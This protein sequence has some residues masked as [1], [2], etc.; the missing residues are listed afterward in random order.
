MKLITCPDCGASLELSLDFTLHRR[1]PA[2]QDTPL[3]EMEL[4]VRSY[5]CL[6]NEA[7]YWGASAETLTAGMIDSKADYQLLCIQNFGRRSLME[8]RGVLARLKG[9]EAQT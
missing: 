9:L 8:V 6:K 7:E 1:N 3:R 5:N 2:W 4:S